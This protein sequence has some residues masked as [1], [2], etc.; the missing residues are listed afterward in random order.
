MKLLLLYLLFGNMTGEPYYVCHIKGNIKF[1]A[2][3]KNVKIGDRIMDTDSLLF[4]TVASNLTVVNSGGMFV[5][6]NLKSLPKQH[7]NGALLIVKEHILP[8]T[9]RGQ[10]YVRSEGPVMNIQALQNYVGVVTDQG[11]V[12]LLLI[13]DIQIKLNPTFFDE[14]DKKYFYLRYTC[15][16]GTINKK[17]N[18]HSDQGLFLVID[19]KIYYVDSKPIDP[20][21]VRDIKLYYYDASAKQSWPVCDLPLITASQEKLEEELK[22]VIEKLGS[23]K[24]RSTGVQNLI[25]TYLLDNYGWLDPDRIDETFPELLK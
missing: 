6:N 12:D 21:E 19:R 20:A 10:L 2:T 17:L 16:S 3:K 18:F 25:A 1:A 9:K 13:N 8:A 15:R 5:I 24:D 14:R 22:V 4:V 7:L 11:N 23:V